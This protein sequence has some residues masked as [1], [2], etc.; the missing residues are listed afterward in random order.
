MARLRHALEPQ[1]PTQKKRSGTGA[2]V[3][4]IAD[5]AVSPD[6]DRVAFGS[7]IRLKV[8]PE[9]HGAVE[10][11]IQCAKVVGGSKQLYQAWAAPSLT[12]GQTDEHDFEDVGLYV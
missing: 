8:S 4:D 5:F 2:G 10:Y 6:A 9:E 7:T 12:K 3:F 1:Q 11:S